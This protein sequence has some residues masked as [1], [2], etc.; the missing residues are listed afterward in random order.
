MS[1]KL[2]GSRKCGFALRQNRSVF[3]IFDLIFLVLEK[4]ELPGFSAFSYALKIV[5]FKRFYS[6]F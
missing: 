5:F 3:P 1:E 2:G 4:A 6:F